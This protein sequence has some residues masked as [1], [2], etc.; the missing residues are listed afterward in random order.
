MP[1]TLPS[2]LGTLLVSKRHKN[3]VA[4]EGHD[5]NCRYEGTELLR[6]ILKEHNKSRGEKIISDFHSGCPKRQKMTRLSKVQ[7]QPAHFVLAAAA[8]PSSVT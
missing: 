8:C 3:N 2:L 1:S 6:K 7:Q 5:G 4:Q